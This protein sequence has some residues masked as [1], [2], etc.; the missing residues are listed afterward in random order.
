MRWA[1]D[2]N[3]DDGIPRITRTK[4]QHLTAKD[5]MNTFAT[6]GNRDMP[7]IKIF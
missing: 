2:F 7:V 1:L 3:K 4:W 5:K 6:K